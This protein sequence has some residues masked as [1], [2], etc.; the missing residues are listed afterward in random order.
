MSDLGSDKRKALLCYHI[1]EIGYRRG[2]HYPLIAPPIGEGCARELPRNLIFGV[3]GD[4][5][6]PRGVFTL[7]NILYI[8]YIIARKDFKAA[9]MIARTNVVI[10]K[11]RYIFLG[12]R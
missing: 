6:P 8:D 12:L 1:V 11:F 2:N 7:F 9:Y 10:E 3:E 5:L 4:G